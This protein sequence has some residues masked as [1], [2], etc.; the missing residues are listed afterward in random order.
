MTT[1]KA[2]SWVEGGRPVIAPQKRAEISAFYQKYADRNIEI[3]LRVL[4]RRSAQENKYYWGCVVP[5]L[6]ECLNSV[7]NEMEAEQAH[8][9]AKQHFNPKHVIGPGGEVIG[10]VGSTTTELNSM[11][12]SDEYIEKIRRFCAEEFSVSIPLPG[13]QSV[14]IA[15]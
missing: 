9:W 15:E 14:L 6:T 2:I 10:T 11:E 8:E 12:F 5:I 4:P 1:L 7:G 3:V 13:E